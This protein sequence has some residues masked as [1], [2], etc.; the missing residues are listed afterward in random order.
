MKVTDRIHVVGSGKNGFS[1]TDSYDCHVYLLNGGDEYALIDAGSGRDVEGIVAAIERDGLDPGRTRQMLLTHA[2]AD[3]AAGAAGLQERLGLRVL[4]SPP[5]AAGVRAADERV[6]SL[7]VARQ[8][9]AYPPDFML[10]RCP[11]DG[12]LADG[13]T[14]QVGDLTVEVVAT[15]GHAAGH[16]SF[17]LRHD[18]QSSVFCGDAFF[19][20]GRILLQNTWDCSV[21]ESIASV[22]RLASL[23]VDGLFPGHFT[24]A[25][26]HGRRQFEPA[27]AS[28]ASLLPPAQLS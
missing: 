24:F 10:R 4:A 26:Q 13:V 20:G 9:G 5:V 17:V 27:L 23:N 2:H 1:L 16:L 15:P 19:F 22:E 28:I 18:G 21:Q 3:H 8:A 6:A 11:V 7:D 12:E 14:V 25:V